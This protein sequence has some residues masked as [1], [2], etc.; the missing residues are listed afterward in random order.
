VLPLEITP[1]ARATLGVKVNG[2]AGEPTPIPEGPP[3]PKPLSG[4]ALIGVA[5]EFVRIAGPQ[6]EADPAGL[7]IQF[8]IAFGNTIGRNP[9]F[10]LAGGECQHMNLYACLVGQ[11]S[12]S[13]KGTAWAVVRRNL[14]W[15]L[16]RVVGTLSSGEGLIHMVHDPVEGKEAI[17]EKG[18][19]VGYQDTILDHGVEDKRVLVVGSEFSSVLRVM[20]REGSTLSAVVRDAF[21]TGSLDIPTRNRPE[22][23]TGAHVSILGHITRDELVKYLVETEQVNG[24]GNRIMWACVQRSKLLSRGGD[25]VNLTAVQTRLSAAIQSARKAGRITWDSEAGELWDANY[26][27]LTRDVPG[28]LGALTARGE[29]ITLRLAC[30]YALL[31]C[32]STIGADHLLAALEVW[33]YCE[34]SAR[35]IF[36]DATGNPDADRILAALRGRP[37]GMTRTDLRDLFDRHKSADTIS[38]ALAVLQRAGL[39]RSEAVQTGGKPAERWFCGVGGALV[40]NP[41]GQNWP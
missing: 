14:A 21:D 31:D 15:D 16:G 26:P 13:R 37:E 6:T 2:K 25:P 4:A 40:A 28:L 20:A 34:V 32:Q 7:L 5:G 3:W 29:A 38:R 35:F 1:E 30:L 33:R 12:R 9:Y 11:S 18:R 24:F 27:H 39:A 10:D 8:L 41:L 36:G 19:I 17:K 22:K 23:A